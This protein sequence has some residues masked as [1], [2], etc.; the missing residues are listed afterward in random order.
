V[1]GPSGPRNSFIGAN[2]ANHRLQLATQESFVEGGA[3][4]IRIID[5]AGRTVCEYPMD[6]VTSRELQIF[7]PESYAKL[8]DSGAWRCEIFNMPRSSRGDDAH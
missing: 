3:Y 8:L 7:L 6:V 5:D 2:Y 4:F 1:S